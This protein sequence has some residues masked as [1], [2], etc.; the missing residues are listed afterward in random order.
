L[1]TVVL[2]GRE[3]WNARTRE[4]VVGRRLMAAWNPDYPADVIAPF[5]NVP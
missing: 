4:T 2:A 5:R 1:R 3:V